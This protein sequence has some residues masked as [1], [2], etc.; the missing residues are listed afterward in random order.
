MASIRMIVACGAETRITQ[1]YAVYVEEAKKHA[2]FV[3]PLI[4]AQ[5]GLVFFGA[6]GAFGLA[7][8]YGTQLYLEDKLNSVGTILVYVLTT[9]FPNQC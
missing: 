2:Q 7:F 8:W 1:R 5:F 6:F 9:S 3:S 4:S